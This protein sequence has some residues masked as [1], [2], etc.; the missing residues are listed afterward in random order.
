MEQISQTRITKELEMLTR[1][2]SKQIKINFSS[3]HKSVELNHSVKG[4]NVTY[5]ITL[6]E[7]YPFL[8]PK[9]TV[10]LPAELES[11]YQNSS[12][13][14]GLVLDDSW[15]PAISLPAL[16]E[17]IILFSNQTLNNKKFSRIGNFSVMSVVAIAIVARFALF[18]QS[19]SGKFTPPLFGDYEAQ[20]HWME[21]TVNYP[22][23]DWYK[24]ESDYWKLDYPP[25][26]AWYSY[27]FGLLSR[28]FDPLSMESFKSRGYS[29]LHHIFFMRFS[30]FISEILLYLP[31][32]LLYFYQLNQHLN[33]KLFSL[34]LLLLLLSPPLILIDYG[35]F[36]YN[37]VMLGFAVLSLTSSLMGSYSVAAGAL[38]LSFNFKIMGLYYFIPLVSY[39]LSAIYDKSM[40]GRMKYGIE[41]KNFTMAYIG[42]SGLITVAGTGFVISCLVWS[43]W[44]GLDD[45]LV[46]L[47]RIFPVDRGVFEDKVATF[48]CVTSVIIKYKQIFS[49]A[50]MG[51]ITG[52]VTLIMTV[53]WVYLTVI[54][55]RFKKS[56]VFG[57]AGS[58][59]TFFLFSYH[60]HEKTILVPLMPL[61]FLTVLE[62]PDLF[63]LII[64]TSTFSLYPLLSLDR[65]KLPYFAFQALFL[66]LSHINKENLKNLVIMKKINSVYIGIAIIHLI[67]LVEMPSQYP[68]LF[69]LIVA[70]YCFA[71]FAYVWVVLLVEF[72][73]L[74]KEDHLLGRSI[75]D[76]TR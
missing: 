52:I 33:Q 2:E 51:I 63:E 29:T 13:I 11:V 7:R 18:S 26:T 70:C 9:V 12:D 16:I 17:K 15:T 54:K 4:V 22:I 74:S 46:V 37:N 73:N 50:T 56:L 34:S 55:R 45:A 1:M 48:W 23:E 69:E 43:P 5:Y 47:A 30:V 62:Y 10:D 38:A 44:I 3:D 31:C 21:I 57:M 14:I 20:R 59:L 71:V 19:Y 65:L 66:A 72:I 25:L 49:V 28:L 64:V 32:V 36:Q 40:R 68:Y 24:V 8:P 61:M 60:V 53:P 42:V 75:K 39:W 27:I 41:L 67:E 35:H 58:A 6:P 76:K